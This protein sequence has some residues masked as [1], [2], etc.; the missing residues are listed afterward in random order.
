MLVCSSLCLALSATFANFA[1]APSNVGAST[2]RGRNDSRRML[3]RDTGRR[4]VSSAGGLDCSNPSTIEA[5]SAGQNVSGAALLEATDSRELDEEESLDISLNGTLEAQITQYGA[6]TPFSF[7]AP[8]DGTVTACVESYDADE[9][10]V[11]QLRPVGG[12][13]GALESLGNV[14]FC[15]RCLSH[16]FGL[17][18]DPVNTATGNFSE[19]FVDFQIPGRGFPLSF[20]HTYNSLAASQNG[21]L[22][23]GWTSN[24]GMSLSQDGS[25]NVTIYQE[26][27]AQVDFSLESG[28]TYTAPPRVVATL[29]KNG[30]GTFTF[31]RLNQQTF[32]F[33]TAGQLINEQDRNGYVTSFGYNAS[34][35]LT[36]V[37]DSAGRSLNLAYTGTHISSVTDPAGRTVSFA[38]DGQGNLQQATDPNGGITRFT[39]DSN[40]LLLTITD[41]S[42]GVLTNAYD[43]S[44][45]VTSQ[46]DPL[47][48]TTT[49][50]YSGDNA[51]ASGGSTT[52][53]DPMGNVTLD[54][55][56]FGLRLATTKGYGT[57]SAATW[58][59][60]YDP[61][62]LGVANSTDPR[63]SVTTNTYDTSGNLLSTTDPL[64]NTTTNT[65]N[66]MNE[67]T[68]TTDPLGVTTDMSYDSNGNLTSQTENG[69]AP[70]VA[71]V[72]WFT[73]KKVGRMVL[74]RWRLSTRSGV[75]GFFLDAKQHRLTRLV[76]VR[77]SRIYSRT[78]LWRG[79]G[80]FW[81]DVQLR[82][83]N[84]ERVR[85]NRAYH[86]KPA[87]RRNVAGPTTTTMYSYGD[88]NHP[89]D[90]TS[91]TD[92]NG[93]TWHYTYDADGN[94]TSATDPLGDKTT[95]VYDNVGELISQTSP[96]G[97]VSGGEPASYTTT[98]QYD[99]LGT[100]T[101]S[102]DPLGHIT[103]RAYDAMGN[104]V[105]VTDANG[106]V[107][108][109]TYDLANELTQTTRPD[110]SIVKTDYNPDGMV[111]DQIDGAGHKT[112][113]GYDPLGHVTSV[114]DPLN[115]VTSYQ[116]FNGNLAYMTN[117]D[118]GST[119]YNYDANNQLTDITYSDDGVTP[120]VSISYDADGQ[121]TA[122][123]DGTGTSSWTYDP[124]HRLTA[125]TDGAG[126]TVGYAYDANGNLT[127]ITYPNGSV[128]SRTFD[129][130]NRLTSVSDWLGNTTSLMYDADSNLTSETF[131][132]GTGETDT[133]SYSAVDQISGISDLGGMTTLASFTYSRDSNNQ[134][135]SATENG[136]PAAAS[137]SY[138]Y[139][140][141]NQLHS[142]NSSLY[143]YDNADNITSLAS[144][145]NL[146]YDAANELTSMSQGGSTTS[147]TFNSEGDRTAVTPP[148]GT[149]ATYTY[150]EA[151]RLTA[152]S[153][154]ATNASYTYNGDGLRMSKTV[155]S[156]VEQ[157]AWDTAQTLPLLITDG[158]TSY[159]YGPGGLPLEQIGSSRSVLFYHH[160]Q[161]GSTR[162]LT[163]SSG[164][165]QATYT[166]DPYGNI[167]AHAGTGDTPFLYTGQYLDSESGLYY[168]RA[169]Y[170]DPT[171][172]QFVTVDPVANLTHSWY[173]YA[174]DDPV[175]AW[176]P[177]GLWTLPGPQC[178]RG[179]GPPLPGQSY[180]PPYVPPQQMT[181][182]PPGASGPFPCVLYTQGVGF[183]NANIGGVIVS[184]NGCQF[185]VPPQPPQIKPP[186]PP[187]YCLRFEDGRSSI[188]P[189]S[190][191]LPP[192]DD[193][194]PDTGAEDDL[195]DG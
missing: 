56:A 80:P 112:A 91:L 165:V 22:G 52:V 191:F 72:A 151:N 24:A 71:H 173:E 137:H 51:A 65:Y 68:S 102:T 152:Y 141:L 14:N 164:S 154:G 180:C 139:T 70:T 188:L 23:Y 107:T 32:T 20:T 143:S 85:A 183:S 168:L 64:G 163:D 69:Q 3:N 57:S 78:V 194:L 119:A 18:G 77:A 131:P 21:P 130:A 27:G 121:R 62:T 147:F 95:Y 100:L 160:D 40:H 33:S 92:A 28:G 116:Y 118:G 61:A 193:H 171:T 157:F 178:L 179:A 148:S 97:N 74:F 87:I 86:T 166:Y 76:P 36:S 6:V 15:E 161:I 134:L 12:P 82:G 172:A 127:G 145:A 105:Q 88:P 37:T 182:C 89:G 133:F 47:G 50:S 185:I 25:G 31:N 104:L 5:V 187:K 158:S 181:Y 90:L 106:N 175:N 149:S 38:Y 63:D 150:D 126:N 169:R 54:I 177:S 17:G 162:L 184:Y 81:L 190:Q 129:G 67:L 2:H 59:Y 48:R 114:A 11:V 124:L 108:Q 41:P 136:V 43:G 159:L 35:Q 176:D 144:G 120:G 113:Y 111:L 66:A 186:T 123:E 189:C 125:S 60:T 30:D 29:V 39:Y 153:S 53:T 132:S 155:N 84:Q 49:F 10:V 128:V 13:P 174:A 101:K 110:G 195:S 58:A 93:N 146:S 94:R 192:I 122:M 44:E 16:A 34:A 167:L 156:V 55:Y 4:V 7:T 99:A 117:P 115:R 142:D 98:Y 140:T 103:Q 135:T 170:Y 45:R 138:S 96:N 79:G 26:N 109:Y 46:T 9:G 75:L 8:S 42:G 73:V 1:F 83:G 19:S